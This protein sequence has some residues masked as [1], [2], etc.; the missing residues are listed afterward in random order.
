VTKSVEIIELD[1]INYIDTPGFNDPNKERSD[2]Q[3]FTDI[4]ENANEIIQNDGI[5]S[6]LQCIMIPESGR[7]NASAF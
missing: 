4:V 5:A 2:C 6:I 1:D 3:I 7:I